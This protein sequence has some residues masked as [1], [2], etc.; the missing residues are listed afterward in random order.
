MKVETL[1]SKKAKEEA[2]KK[3][4]GRFGYLTFLIKVKKHHEQYDPS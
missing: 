4:I 1:L 2:I 3:K